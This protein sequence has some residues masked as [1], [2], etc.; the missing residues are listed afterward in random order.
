MVAKSRCSTAPKPQALQS[1]RQM[2]LPEAASAH[3]RPDEPAKRHR[4]GD[5]LE[6]MAAALLGDE[7]TGYLARTRAVTTTES[8]SAR[9][10]A[11]CGNSAPAY[12]NEWGAP[13]HQSGIGS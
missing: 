8:G 9:T 3:A 2:P 13:T 10:C 1:L 5:A 6:F 4:L 12:T 11:S 7:H